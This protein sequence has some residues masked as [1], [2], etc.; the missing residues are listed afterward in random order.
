VGSHGRAVRI[1][2]RN[3][4]AERRPLE[5]RVLLNGREADRRLLPPDGQWRVIRLI[6]R[7]ESEFSR[8]DLLT[9]L[10]GSGLPLNIP[11]TDRS[12]VMQVRRPTI[13]N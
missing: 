4:D 11:A 13:E 5:V 2:L 10:T 12:G 9:G 8:I 1:P 7:H 3:T 6:L